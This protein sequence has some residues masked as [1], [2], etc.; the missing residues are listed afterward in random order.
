MSELRTDLLV[1]VLKRAQAR[2][3]AV[4]HVAA[5]HAVLDQHGALRGR[6]LVVDGERAAPAGERAVVHH[7]HAG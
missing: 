4:L 3:Q 2:V 1:D 5:Q 7:R 6:A